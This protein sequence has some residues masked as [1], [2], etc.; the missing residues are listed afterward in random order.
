M[1]KQATNR[2]GQ[3]APGKKQVNWRINE[4]DVEN[5]A[6]EAVELSLGSGKAPD[7]INYLLR[8]YFN[9]E[10]IKRPGGKK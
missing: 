3:V 7:F 5:S 10:A 9:G 4:D 6:G 2:R 8:R 1:V